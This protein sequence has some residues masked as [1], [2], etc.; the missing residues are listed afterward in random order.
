MY[1]LQCFHWLV[2]VSSSDTLLYFA[3]FCAGPSPEIAG[4]NDTKNFA[5]LP[6]DLTIIRGFRETR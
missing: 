4:K 2:Q 6:N 1:K 3:R 5:W